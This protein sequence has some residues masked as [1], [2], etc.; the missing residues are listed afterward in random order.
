MRF[1]LDVFRMEV[2]E[3]GDNKISKYEFLLYELQKINLPTKEELKSYTKWLIF[4]YRSII[5]LWK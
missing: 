1:H 5:L 2:D 3:D 4:F